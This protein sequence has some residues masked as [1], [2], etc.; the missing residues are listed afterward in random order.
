[1]STTET[2]DTDA[3]QSAE[4]LNDDLKSL[5]STNSSE[6][7]TN[8]K[9]KIDLPDEEDE[10]EEEKATKKPSNKPR[11]GSPDKTSVKV[12]AQPSTPVKV[13]RFLTPITFNFT[14]KFIFV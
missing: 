11:N 8:G 7:H 6:D 14:F 5:A 3:K 12:K 13:R 2:K 9:L 10:E 1:M 4:D